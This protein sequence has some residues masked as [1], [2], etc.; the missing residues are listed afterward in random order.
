M[1]EFGCILGLLAICPAV[2]LPADD[3]DLAAEFR[4]ARP[5]IMQ[6]LRDKD[7]EK[8]AAAVQKLES[9]PTGEAVKLLLTQVVA[10]KDEELRRAG[11]AALLKL[12]GD[13]EVCKLLQADVAKEWKAARPDAEGFAV[14]EALLASE[15]SAP[16]DQALQT[17]QQAVARTKNGRELLILLTDDL[18]LRTGDERLAALQQLITLPQFKD[19][20]A[21]RRTITQ[22]ITRIRSKPAISQLIDL[23]RQTDGEVRTDIIHYLTHVTG[24]ELGRDARQ[25]NTWWQQN[26]ESFEFPPLDLRADAVPW[27][28]RGIAG[29]SYY[30][31]PLT[32]SRI[33]FVMDTSSSMNIGGR[34]IAAKRELT[35]AIGELPA[36]VPFNVVVF[37]GRATAWRNKLVPANEDNKHQ[38]AYFVAAQGLASGTASYDALEAAINQDAEAIYFV[39]DGAPFGGKITNPAE[40]VQTITRLNQFRRTTIHCFGIGVGPEGN[41]FDA[42]LAK[43]SQ[44]NYGQYRRV[45]E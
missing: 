34:I 4:S 15:L 25:W 11:F 35:R 3:R 22:A 1:R 38:A 19:D 30:K 12:N 41:P 26:Q 16:A 5:A 39:T 24:Q 31:V 21:V 14:L 45:D 20:F 7:R 18:A 40:I 17:L 8:R 32:A 10:S 44:Q 9:Y 37:N 33:L 13:E 23:L 27:I 42:F 43:L 6:Q 36:E 2:A 28:P 29:P